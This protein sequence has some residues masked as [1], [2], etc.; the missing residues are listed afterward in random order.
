MTIWETAV[1]A[2]KRTKQ[3][4]DLIR[5]AVKNGDLPAYAIGKGGRDYRL[6]ASEVDAWMRS[7]SYEP[8]SA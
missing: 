7:R 6:D 4:A 2:A 5:S 1:E 3:S 8:R